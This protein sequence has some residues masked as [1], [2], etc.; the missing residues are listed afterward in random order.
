MREQLLQENNIPYEE[1]SIRNGIE[2]SWLDPEPI[3]TLVQVSGTELR[4]EK[5]NELL[6]KITQQVSGTE[7][8]DRGR[9]WNTA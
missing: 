6:D 7:L 2:R 9:A 5:M 1:A 8:R 4:V 3:Q